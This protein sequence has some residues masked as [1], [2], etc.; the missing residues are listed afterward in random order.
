MAGAFGMAFAWWA[1]PR[2]F[3][4]ASIDL[5]ITPRQAEQIGR[6]ALRQLRPDLDLS[7]WRSAVKFAWD[8]NAKFYLEKTLGLAQANTVMREQVSVWFFE[9][10]W[11]REGERTRYW[12]RV[13]PS[14]RVV[15]AGVQIPEEMLGASL[16]RD[17]ARQIAEQFLREQLQV[18]LRAWRLLNAFEYQR[19]NRRDYTFVYEHRT[20]KY[21]ADSPTPATLRLSIS[22]A[23]DAVSGYSLNWLHTPDKWAFEQRQ[24]ESLRTTLGYIFGSLDTLFRLVAIGLVV[25]LVVRRQPLGWRFALRIALTLAGVWTLTSLNFAPLWWVTYNPAVPEINFLAGRLLRVAIGALIGIALVWFLFALTAEWL[26]RERP[27]GGVPLAK[28]TTL[29]FWTTDAAARALLIGLGAAGVHLAYVCAVY[30]LSSQ[31][32]V[33]S[34]LYVPYTNGVATPL[35]FMEPLFYGLLPAVQEELFYRG[36]VLYLLWRVLK[37][38]WVAAFFSS[39]LWAFLHVGYPTEPAYVRGLEL[40]P[41]GLAFCW[42]AQRYGLLAPVAA[43]YTYNALLTAYT[44]L[45]MDA[46]YLRLSAL[47]TGLGVLLLLLPAVIMRVRTGRLRTLEEVDPPSMDIP[48]PP[49]P[50]EPRVA[51]YRPLQRWEWVAFGAGLIALNTYYYAYY[52]EPRKREALRT[53]TIDRAAAIERAR[54]YLQRIGAPIE[55]YQAIVAYVEA[56]ADDDAHAYARH[57]DQEDAYQSLEKQLRRQDYW[58]VRFFRPQE[59]TE[60]LVSLTL[61][62]KVWDIVRRL[63][64]ESPG[65][66]PAERGMR[67]VKLTPSEAR[68]RAEQ[69]LQQVY[70]TDPA[71]WRL[72]ESD[73]IERPNRYDYQF[74]YEHRTLRFGEA[75]RRLVVEVQGAL[76]HD[77]VEFWHLPQS[78]RFEQRRFRA[79][80]V[81]VAAWLL[82]LVLALLGYMLFWEWREGN[83]TSFS[84]RL[85]LMAAGIGLLCGGAFVLSDWENSLWGDYD[86]AQPPA[87]HLTLTGGVML[88]GVVLAGLLVG[89]LYAGLEPSYWRTRLG[90]LVPLTVWL[91]P[92]RWRTVPPDS[93]LRHPRAQREGWFI[94]ALTSGVVGLSSYFFPDTSDS[95]GWSLPWLGDCAAAGLVTLVFGALALGAVGLYRRYIRT[96]WRLA[97]LALLFAPAAAIG[98]ASWEEVRE[99]MQIYALVWAVGAPLAFWLGRRLLQGNLF[100]WAHMLLLT[101]VASLIGTYLNIPNSTL[102]WNGWILLAI[103]GVLL[104]ASYWIAR[105]MSVPAIEAAVESL[106]EAVHTEYAVVQIETPQPQPERGEG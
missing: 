43:H 4:E 49:P 39:L 3:P 8:S 81:F 37:R 54:E 34:P 21:P 96:V 67:Q 20:R 25:W 36:V 48:P 71:D 102:R 31:L 38:F 52:Y 55:G 24:R 23:G 35:P 74:T 32:G 75:R 7:D 50:V 16:P 17:A 46:S 1:Y 44:Y 100:A 69:Y 22:V 97:L 53:L 56:E 84:M 72:I 51:P 83:A 94:A 88:F 60:W 47:V 103:Y 41:V 28:I 89:A 98:A 73:R 62:G 64:E 65:N 86:P 33:W 106:P 18:D 82:T 90:H 101:L 93:P 30:Q 13:S 27:L 15:G 80:E 105:R 104:V 99:R 45:N 61:D 10:V 85:A 12:A 2:V 79:W 29:R 78:W 9:G 70:G 11:K 68:T 5:T 26:N 91:S 76:A 57:I 66:L 63:P 92:A 42:L 59:R 58:S 95:V 40:L 19:P 14:G 87:L 77:A 6:D